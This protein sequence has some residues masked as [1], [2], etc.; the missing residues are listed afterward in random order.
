MV[1]GYFLDENLILR[2]SQSAVAHTHSENKN[3]HSLVEHL[4]DVAERAA[5]FA[6]AFGSGDWAYLAGLWHDLG[7]YHPLFQAYLN[8]G[9]QVRH[10][11]G[12]A[13]HALERFGGDSRGRILA[14]LI[15]CHHTGLTDWRATE[16]ATGKT[17]LGNRLKEYE[18]KNLFETVKAQP[19]PD[20]IRHAPLPS[21]RPPTGVDRDLGC[22]L[23]IR[24]LFSCLVD[25]DFLDTE[26]YM[27]RKRSDIRGQYPSLEELR[28][29]LD[30]HLAALGSDS[31]L[32][33]IRVDILKQCRIKANDVSGLFSLTVPTG[34]GKTLSSMAFALDHAIKHGKK[35]V[36]YIIPYT[37]IIEQN[38]RVFKNIFGEQN[39]IEHHSNFDFN[40]EDDET[41]WN[42]HKLACE[43][44]DAPI[45]VT[46]NVQF[47][48]SLFAAKTSRVR[49]LHNIVNSVVI[50]DEAQLLPVEFLSPVLKTIEQLQKVYKATLVFCTA[51]QPALTTQNPALKIY[52][53]EEKAVR[54]IIDDPIG[55]AKKL[56]RV[57][58][59]L[60][61][62]WSSPCAWD[63]LASEL[64][65]H[66]RVLCIVNQ[67]K[68]A[69]ELYEILR[70]KGAAEN[71]M[72]YH[73]SALMCPAHRTSV[74]E[75]IKAKL[76]DKNSMPLR[77][78]STQLIE[79]GVDIDF[80][81]VYRALAGLDS[82]AQAAGRCNREGNLGLKGGKV[83]VFIPPKE[84]PP[85]I[86]RKAAD[87]GKEVLKNMPDPHKEWLTPASFTRFFNKLYSDANNHDKKQIIAELKDQGTFE[88]QFLSAARKFR[89]IDDEEQVSVIVP[90]GE[91]KHLLASIRA[92]GGE[93]IERY[94][95][96][97]LQPYTVSIR[98][99]VFTDRK[100]AGKI[101]PVLT[102]EMGLYTVAEQNQ[103]KLD[104]GLE[105][106]ALPLL[107]DW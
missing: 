4:Q 92:N 73:L 103:Y 93:R 11:L 59:H 55:L 51:T 36:I 58:I 47:F 6:D 94:L 25:A 46:T 64:L 27:D 89:L 88:F 52:G 75:E 82:I 106:S 5:G 80:P 18:E 7:K 71:G 98:R 70:D 43:N 85:G 39:V 24:M 8:G 44:W 69:R 14:W 19:L 29:K 74:I 60:P 1:Y 104:V 3:D 2:D 68:D 105:L 26:E 95:L 96:R 40:D 16:E 61:A 65:G 91:G 72:L 49:K 35:R 81:V 76:Q 54:E 38:A 101:V 32:N 63:D 22:T 30:A 78:V 90:Y 37:S 99:R 34:G 9:S 28:L 86:L 45:I 17:P 31:E 57:T 97:R 67:R 15:A 41:A 56:E 83:V 50:L 84:A 62:D 100:H 53:L 79:A 87:A 66:E 10:A 48:E 23:W 77:L 102:E 33:R 21:S 107:G 12:G 20:A 13:L 42:R